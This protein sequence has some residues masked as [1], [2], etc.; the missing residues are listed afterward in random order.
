MCIDR[1]VKGLFELLG[2]DGT[3]IIF[4][5]LTIPYCYRGF[6]ID[7]LFHLSNM[8]EYKIYYYSKFICTDGLQGTENP[9]YK[10]VHD[11]AVVL[12]T[13]HSVAY[14]GRRFYNPNGMI[15]DKFE[16]Q[17]YALIRR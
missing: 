11:I 6:T 16:Y 14:N 1:P 9:N 8:L 2:H 4:P 15:Q 7:D 12:G 3:E 17:S 10:P 5:E 13:D